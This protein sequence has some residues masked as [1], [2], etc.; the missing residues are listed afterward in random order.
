MLQRARIGTKFVIIISA[1]MIVL[2]GAGLSLYVYQRYSQFRAELLAQ[3]KGRITLIEAF[4][5]EAML[6]RL[7]TSDGDPVIAALDGTFEELQNTAKD[8][9]VWLAM[10]P[11]VLE[12]QG[13]LG[14]AQEP[15]ADE[16]GKEAVATK[17]PASRFIDD[18]LRYSQPVILGKGV[19]DQ[20]RCFDCHGKLMGLKKGD[21][22]GL[23]SLALDISGPNAA[24][25]SQILHLIFGAMVL[26]AV[27]AAL[28]FLITRKMISNPVAMIVSAMKRL[29]QGQ[30]GITIPGRGCPDEIG[31]IASAL[32]VFR[33]KA[34]EAEH[35]AEENRKIEAKRSEE[36]KQRLA[37]EA[38]RRAEEQK[39]EAAAR[40]EA[41]RQLLSEMAQ[42]FE[43]SVD[44][45]LKQLEA[46][47]RKMENVAETLVDTAQKGAMESNAVTNATEATTS[48]VQ[49]VAAAS[50][51]LSQSISE[52]SRQME[53]TRNIS[54]R[55]VQDAGRSTEAVGRLSE[56]AE[57]IG[58][59][60]ALISDIAEQTNLLALNATIEAARAGDA[61]K[62]FAVVA[63]EVKNLA[64]Q[65]A[66]ATEDISRQI[67][68]MQEATRSAVEAIQAIN[69]VIGNINNTA[70]SVSSAID[71][72]AAATGE[73]SGNAQ[74]A[75]AAT[76]E[77][78]AK[79]ATVSD[80]A[81]RT[82]A[83]AEE[84]RQAVDELKRITG[85]LQNDIGDFIG[86]LRS[87]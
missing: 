60:V 47:A 84:T 76:A 34:L 82:G 7:D 45:P 42:S 51:E 87:A 15:P 13:K 46:S 55:A 52:I 50:E 67:S 49:S 35:L 69:E 1:A 77:I 61:G 43:Q 62:G 59:V 23:Y 80:Y 64:T 72:Q 75:H 20:S 74:A 30:Y 5:T 73:I 28:N 37:M 32:E 40:D 79:I 63:S 9:R 56:T 10:G 41:R 86:R 24:F 39:R 44:A 78:S 2:I 16:I 33:E 48:N 12:Y 65:T 53:Q 58:E 25:R 71:Q 17:R 18:T 8:I 11:K 26:I 36:E 6:N 19:A 83:S 27:I 85:L 21:V 68:D 38:A 29:S 22:I 70:V 81:G 4:H 54:E 3:A 31:E 14:N 66:R 57:R